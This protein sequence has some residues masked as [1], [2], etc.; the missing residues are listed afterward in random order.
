MTEFYQQT[1]TI[2]ALAHSESVL[3]YEPLFLLC[4]TR[5][6]GKKNHNVLLSEPTLFKCL[7]LWRRFISSSPVHFPTSIY[8][9]RQFVPLSLS[10]HRDLHFF[11]HLSWDIIIQ[12]CSDLAV[13]SGKSIIHRA[14]VS[15]QACIPRSR[16]H[17]GIYNQLSTVHEGRL[18]PRRQKGQANAIEIPPMQRA[19]KL[20]LRNIQYHTNMLLA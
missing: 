9:P 10:T 2:I 1:G 14:N 12:S 6:M 13:P 3:P 18:A 5:S 19:E 11:L 15:K 20:L 4:K 8:I 16:T 7:L 17:Q